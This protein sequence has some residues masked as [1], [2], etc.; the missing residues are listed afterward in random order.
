MG[1]SLRID[2]FLVKKGIA[3]SRTKAQ[4]LIKMGSVE[5]L[6]NGEWI[7]VSSSSLKVSDKDELRLND[8]TTLKYVSRGG[9]KLEG[10]L[11]DFA[12]DV[13]GMNA[14]DVGQSTGG[15]TDCLLQHGVRNVLGI[16]VGHDQLAEVIKKNPRVK[17]LEGVHIKD[18]PEHGEILQW[19]VENPVDLCVVDVSFISVM[20]VFEA[21]AQIPVR[22]FKILALVKPQFEVGRSE[23]NKSG[24]V[25]DS[26]TA[27]AF[28]DKV[29]ENVDS[30]GFTHRGV[31]PSAIAGGDG[32][33]EYFL[34]VEKS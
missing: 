8:A 33:Q 19:F 7:S 31:K 4:E 17:F 14:L 5:I 23:L 30:M 2:H 13:S 12:L 28:V 1:D 21:L 3:P 16:D 27:K 26:A 6:K 10:A 9:L 11:K 18:L 22:G 34:L 29:V 32:N 20:K 24:I 25:K 15:F